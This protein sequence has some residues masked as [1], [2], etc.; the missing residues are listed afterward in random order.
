VNLLQQD[1]YYVVCVIDGLQAVSNDL[2]LVSCDRQCPQTGI[3]ISPLA[4][5]VSLSELR[6][7]APQRREHTH[8]HYI[9]KQLLPNLS[10]AK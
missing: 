5:P 2:A 3:M 1:F 10:H 9:P 8:T 6:D 7:K 4:V